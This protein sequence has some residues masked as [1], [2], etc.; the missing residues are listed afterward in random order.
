MPRFVAAAT[1]VIAC[2]LG[3]VACG[4][5]G[6]SNNGGAGA[7]ARPTTTAKLA[8]LQPTSGQVEGPQV[9]LQ[10]QLT[11]GTLAPVS[12]NLQL[13]PNTGHIHVYVDGALVT[14]S[15]GLTTTLPTLSPGLHTI[16]AEFVANDHLPWANRVVAA[17]GFT[18]Q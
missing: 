13:E 15:P 3:L 7:P 17:V 9:T 12:G 14:M 4:N 16:R 8:I 6:A 18:V 10:M 2:L 1:L 11:G 5:D